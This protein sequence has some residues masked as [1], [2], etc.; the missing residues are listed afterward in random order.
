MLRKAP[1][2]RPHLSSASPDTALLWARLGVTYK[3]NLETREWDSRPRRRHF[4]W[5]ISRLVG[6]SLLDILEKFTC[7]L[8]FF[9]WYR[10]LEG[11]EV[12]VPIMSLGEEAL[13]R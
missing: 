11:T 4:V 13:S 7:P 1:L 9:P 6:Q 8:T 12:V 5:C 10:R 2:T 3:R